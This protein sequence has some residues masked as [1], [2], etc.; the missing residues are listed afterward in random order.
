MMMMM[1][2]MMVMVK[3]KVKVK[4]NDVDETH[5]HTETQ[6]FLFSMRQIGSMP[7]PP[8]LRGFN[9]NVGS[10]GFFFKCWDHEKPWLLL[11]SPNS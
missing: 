3:V 8:E 1:M 10:H 2:M 4:D 7:V 9:G 11:T 6:T 5:T